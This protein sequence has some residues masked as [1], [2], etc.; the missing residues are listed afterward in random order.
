MSS[1]EGTDLSTD[2]HLQLVFQVRSCAQFL[3]IRPR[4]RAAASDALAGARR[5]APR[6]AARPAPPSQYYCRFG[7]TSGSGDEEEALDNANLCVPRLLRV[8]GPPPARRCRDDSRRLRAPSARAA[9][10]LPASA[11]GCWTAR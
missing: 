2:E 3:G 11:R 4:V 7:R 5:S 9:P 10:S 6:F 1:T 8:R